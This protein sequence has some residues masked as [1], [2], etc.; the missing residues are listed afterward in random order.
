MNVTDPKEKLIK[1]LSVI[2]YSNKTNLN[3]QYVDESALY[4]IVLI[5][6]NKAYH[7]KY[8]DDDNAQ[9][10]FNSFKELTEKISTVILEVNPGFKYPNTTATMLLELANISKFNAQHLPR[11]TDVKAEKNIE[12]QTLQ[13]LSFYIDKLIIS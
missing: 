9:G 3:I 4:R 5:E 6:G 12:E 11:L 8:V 7:G 2:I 1:I 10:F 13:I